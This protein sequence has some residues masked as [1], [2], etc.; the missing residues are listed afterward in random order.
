MSA[1]P[2]HNESVSLLEAGTAN[3]PNSVVVMGGG[4]T[5]SSIVKSMRKNLSKRLKQRGPKASHKKKRKQGGG[6]ITNPY[7]LDNTTTYQTAKTLSFNVQAETVTA[8]Q[9]NMGAVLTAP[10]ILDGDIQVYVTAAKQLWKR[11][12]GSSTVK[13]LNMQ[14]I[15]PSLSNPYL[16]PDMLTPATLSKIET[17]RLSIALNTDTRNILLFPSIAGSIEMFQKCIAPFFDASKRLVTTNPNTCMLFPPPFFGT[18][19]DINTNLFKYYILIKNMIVADGRHSIYILTPYSAEHLSQ[20]YLITEN[21]TVERKSVIF[22]LLEPTYVIFPFSVNITMPPD[23]DIPDTRGGILFSA[24]N[25][26]TKEPILPAAVSSPPMDGLLDLIL[27]TPADT[28]SSVAFLP[29]LTITDPKLDPMN[30]RQIGITGVVVDATNYIIIPTDATRDTGPTFGPAFLGDPNAIIASVSLT[31]I[32]L[33]TQAYSLRASVPDVIKDWKLAIFT[34]EEARFLNDLHMNPSMLS[35][36]FGMGWKQELTKH[37]ITITRS[38]CFTDANLVLNADCQGTKTFIAKIFEEMVKNS[39]SLIELETSK[40]KSKFASLRNIIEQQANARF[41]GDELPGPDLMD[42]NDFTDVINYI[43]DE[44]G[45]AKPS[46]DT[47][48]FLKSFNDGTLPRVLSVFDFIASPAQ[49]G[50]PPNSV[51]AS[52]IGILTAKDL[53]ILGKLGFTP[54][55]VLVPPPAPPVPGDPK[56]YTLTFSK[57]ISLDVLNKLA[58]NNVRRYMMVVG[59]EGDDPNINNLPNSRA[60]DDTYTLRLQL[61]KL[62]SLTSRVSVHAELVMKNSDP[63]DGTYTVDLING[64]LSALQGVYAVMNMSSINLFPKYIF[65][66][67]TPTI[68]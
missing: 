56:T 13:G 18:D 20:A 33:G 30:Y 55:A 58:N 25:A 32:T 57:P 24:A 42:V 45:V 17:D 7:V 43:T 44:N 51:S 65:E 53:D 8:A 16:K 52:Y 37:L 19:V 6:S 61:T 11:S 36:V 14:M 50:A 49:P 60:S 54:P 15:I 64:D 47:K 22:P 39:N 66:L 5:V 63:K 21:L 68:I 67:P 62:I 59:E 27:K 9:I 4:A 48:A 31:P 46:L 2:G 40:A 29:N 26:P 28:S 23:V 35:K 10:D 1:P 41:K 38:K 34:E 12:G 3:I